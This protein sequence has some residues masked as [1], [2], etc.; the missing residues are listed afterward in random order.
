MIIADYLRLSRTNF[1]FFRIFYGERRSEADPDENQRR[2]KR[3]RAA[4]HQQQI[5]PLQICVI[6]QQRRKLHQQRRSGVHG[7]GEREHKGEY[8]GG[9]EVT[10]VHM[11]EEKRYAE[12]EQRGG[13]EHGALGQSAAERKAHAEHRRHIYERARHADGRCEL[14]VFFWQRVLEKRVHGGGVVVQPRADARRLVKIQRERLGKR[15]TEQ[16]GGQ[17]ERHIR[18]RKN[19]KML[20]VELAVYPQHGI[21]RQDEHRLKLEAER[22]RGE[23]HGGDGAVVKRTVNAQQ[24]QRGIDAVALRPERAVE[25]HR[26]QHEHREEYADAPRRA[27]R[28][29]PEQK[30]RAPCEQHVEEYA[31]QLYEIEIV[32]AAVGKEREKIEIRYIIVAYL[33]AQPR[34]AAVYAEI[35]D[36]AGEKVAVVERHVVQ[37]RIPRGKR[38]Q[39]Q[40]G[41]GSPM[42]RRG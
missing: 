14:A 31:Q 13:G 23:R 21:H 11:R 30:R 12:H 36:P 9:E 8:I 15:A 34:K 6:P 26:G 41:G 40:R 1:T 29:A 37:H 33:A 39:R 3:E 24:R 5:P 7:R 38:Q 20:P 27:P 4:I 25:E 28:E 17:H 32:D 35:L 18:R 42:P 16:H 22:E 10:L 2:D 19:E